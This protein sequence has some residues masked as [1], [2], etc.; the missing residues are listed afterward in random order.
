MFNQERTDKQHCL[1]FNKFVECYT[2]HFCV[3]LVSLPLITV[4]SVT[5]YLAIN[6]TW[7]NL[8]NG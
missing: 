4:L 2:T 5:E 1:M 8:F 7:Q 3:G 6:Y